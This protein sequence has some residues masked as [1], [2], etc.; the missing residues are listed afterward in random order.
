MRAYTIKVV[1]YGK[2][3]TVHFKYAAMTHPQE[4]ECLDIGDK[5]Y[6]VGLVTHKLMSG[7][8]GGGEYHSLNYVEL[9]VYSR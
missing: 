4:G 3:D 1:A 2:P 7:R 8:D 5:R 9:Q 6:V